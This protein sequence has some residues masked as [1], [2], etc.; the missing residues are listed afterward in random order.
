ME[1]QSKIIVIRQFTKDR[2]TVWSFL[3]NSPDWHPQ[4]KN[5]HSNADGTTVELNDGT[6]MMQ[7]VVEDRESYGF[8]Y[9]MINS[10]LPLGD[11]LAK[12]KV[13]DL[14][15]KNCVVEWSSTF[16]AKGVSKKQA[17]LLV[18]MIYEDGLKKLHDSICHQGNQP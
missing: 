7:E 1:E 9:C 14:D 12:V 18:Q 13:H 17:E 4:S 8:G 5:L 16:Y 6:M 10:P 3:L 2:D 11:Y 15:G